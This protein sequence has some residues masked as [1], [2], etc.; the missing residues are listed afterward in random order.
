[1]AENFK[2]ITLIENFMGIIDSMNPD[3]LP[4]GAMVD[5]N[6]VVCVKRNQVQVRNGYKKV[7]FDEE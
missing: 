2:D 6:N 7:V 4:A 1:M 5:Q 3:M